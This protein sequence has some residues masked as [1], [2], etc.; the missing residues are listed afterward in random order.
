MKKVIKV[1]KNEEKTIVI[2]KSGEYIVKLVGEGASVQ[3]LGVLVGRKNDDFTIRT[4][5]HHLAPNTR[6]DLLIKTVLFDETHLDYDGLIK[7]EKKARGSD[8][9]QRNENLLMDK[10]VVAQSKPELEIEADSV[11]C[12]HAATIGKI[13]EEQLFYLQTRGLS[14]RKAEEVLIDGFLSGVFDRIENAEKRKKLKKEIW[15]TLSMRFW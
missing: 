1:K 13:N 7:I 8:A 3:I 12:T 14:R 5:Q 10:N 11:R 2:D 15:Q 4:V 6:S 9:F